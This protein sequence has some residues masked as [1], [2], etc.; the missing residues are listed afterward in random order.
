MN[1]RII[2]AIFLLA[3]YFILNN[4]Q[5]ACAQTMAGEYLLELGK[6]SFKQGDLESA[7]AEFN[8]VLL[9]LPNNK[10]ANAYLKLISVKKNESISQRKI[11]IADELNNS[12]EKFQ[13]TQ[14]PSKGDKTPKAKDFASSQK[15]K[16]VK[17]NPQ[18][19]S[20]EKTPEA[21][22]FMPP[23]EK[24]AWTIPK[25]KLY[26]EVYSKYFWHER[27]FD[28]KKHKKMWENSG[29]YHE[30]R[31]EFKFEYGITNKLT[32][33]AY[34]PYVQ[35]TWKDDA[36]NGATVPSGH[37]FRN[38]GL[39][40][41][42]LGFKYNLFENPFVFTI[43]I[44]T[45]V[46]GN[47]NPN[48][49]PAALGHRQ[50]DEELRLMF[51]KSF[52]FFLPMYS[53][54]ETGYRWRM[55]HPNRNDVPADQVPYFFELGISPLNWLVLKTT[56]DG[57]Q[58]IRSTGKETLTWK[59][60]DD[61]Q[62]NWQQVAI[63]TDESYTKWTTGFVFKLKGFNIET[64]YGKTFRGKNTSAAKEMILSLSYLF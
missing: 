13:K 41:Y 24:G 17:P 45:K 2:L 42:W 6:T 19:P 4:S 51:G 57:V 3:I 29:R 35:A 49:Q 59:F 25:G 56:L 21:S 47:Y 46:P 44:R 52:K 58:G 40:D 10:E 11:A 50:V 62:G 9:I 15:D 33:L 1:K 27:Y 23:A 31:I 30:K 53:K 60:N 5:D 18:Q 16:T 61:G 39:A 37:H 20:E 28:D 38:R 64:S 36:F 7:K 48:N 34:L 8:K 12:E 55:D 14:V 43:M 32:A 54:F 22:D 63:G 26:L